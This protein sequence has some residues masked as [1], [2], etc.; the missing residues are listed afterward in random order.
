MSHPSSRYV[1]CPTCRFPNLTGESRCSQCDADLHEPAVEAPPSA[2]A[3]Y[4]CELQNTI[5]AVGVGLLAGAAAAVIGAVVSQGLWL[6]LLGQWLI[7]PTRPG[8]KYLGPMLLAAGPVLWIMGAPHL[9]I[10]GRRN[11]FETK[12]LVVGGMASGVLTLALAIVG[13]LVFRAHPDNGAAATD[14]L[15]PTAFWMALHL[16]CQGIAVAVAVITLRRMEALRP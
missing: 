2:A 13:F 14:R 10:G 8:Q 9:E 6:A 4:S 1:R 11:V 12:E 3:D 7:P 5:T 15:L 16:I